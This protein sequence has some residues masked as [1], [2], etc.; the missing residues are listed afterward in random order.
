MAQP[1]LE[2]REV[3]KS[4]FRT[5]ALSDVTFTVAPGRIVGLVG[6]NG[7]GKSTLMNILGGVLAP[8][9]GWMFL[10]GRPYAPQDPNDAAAE[11]VALVHQE[12]NLLPNLSIAENLFLAD[13]PRHRVGPLRWIDRRTLRQK[14]DDLLKAVQ[15]TADASTP[16]EKLSPGERQLVEIA[17]ALKGTARIV[18]FD[19]PTTSLTRLEARRLF[20][21]I[22]RLRD[23]GV[24]VIYISHAL[25]DVLALCDQIVVLRDGTVQAVGDRADFTAQR[26]I[27]LMV[28]RSM[29]ALFPTR[30]AA[31]SGE[32]LL[33]VRGLSQTGVVE[34]INFT[35]HRGELLGIAGLMGSGRTE[36]ARMLFGLDPFERGEI[37]VRGRPLARPTPRACIRHGVGFLTEDR[38][39]EGLLLDAS[40]EDNIALAS[41]P[42]FASGPLG[43][44]RRR[45]LRE[46]TAG[47]VHALAIDCRGMGQPVR[48]LSGGNQQ[49]IVLARWLMSGADILMVDEPT[50]G[51]DVQARYEIY[52]QIGGVAARGGGVLW[53][54]SELEE[55]VGLCDRII[56]MG[57]GEIQSIV[58]R[59]EFDRHA[60]LQAALG[61]ERLL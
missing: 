7:A 43:I 14:S 27:A 17:R 12:L 15:L 38:A 10:N 18:V 3:S 37:R 26:L 48:T 32:V 20:E 45:R 47:M 46:K 11:G 22:R 36:L 1:M 24:S 5:R 13:L 58:R 19:E 56:V 30:D 55:L 28:G 29:D 44:V 40:V 61:T 2:F 21:I 49:K 34:N 16:V 59:D 31:T 50:R 54:S 25:A 52:Q 41:L 39:A 53:I 33:E 51:V 23:S 60:M 9:R 6:E 8:D 42:A 35:L 57:R 4:F